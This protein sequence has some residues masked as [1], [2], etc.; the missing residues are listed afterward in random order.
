MKKEEIKMGSYVYYVSLGICQVLE[1]VTM[2]EDESSKDYLTL[3]SINPKNSVKVFVP[4]DNPSQLSN[5]LS[6][7]SQDQILNAIK[8]K[9]KIIEWNANKRERQELFTSCLHSHNIMD[10][11]NLIVCLTKK[12]HELRLEKKHLSSSDGEILQKASYIVKEAVSFAFKIPLDEA[13]TFIIE[14]VNYQ[15]F[16]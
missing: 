5:I 14:N 3:Q 8:A 6:T 9:P 15:L 7:L 10:I 1:T 4:L 12:S 11:I 16:V 2:G 13:Y